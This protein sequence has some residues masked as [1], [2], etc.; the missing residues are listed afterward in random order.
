MLKNKHTHT[1]GEGGFLKFK[2]A[3]TN[4]V[5]ICRSQFVGAIEGA[6]GDGGW[7]GDEETT[8]KC[9]SS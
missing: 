8:R 6:V 7:G 9:S 1:Q 2:C 5:F 4:L 3:D